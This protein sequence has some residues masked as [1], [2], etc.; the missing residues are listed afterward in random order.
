MEDRVKS[1]AKRMV[2]R[3][4]D[5]KRTPD[6]VVGHYAATSSRAR[7]ARA[8]TD[9]E[10]RLAGIRRFLAACD[11]LRAQGLTEE[12]IAEATTDLARRSGATDEG[13]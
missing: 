5:D 4:V 9:G 10:Q 12:Q 3:I 8:K 2:T 13:T 6:A 7:E 11:R 1:I